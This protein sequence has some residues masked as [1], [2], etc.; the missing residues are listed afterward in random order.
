[1]IVEMLD[2][3]MNSTV[4]GGIKNTSLKIMSFE[5]SSVRV[6]LVEVFSI[7]GEGRPLLLL[8]FL[9]LPREHDDLT[10]WNLLS[11]YSP[12]KTGTISQKEHKGTTF[13]NLNPHFFL[14]ISVG[15]I[16]QSRGSNKF[17]CALV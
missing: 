2:N 3:A 9:P 17:R 5:F 13:L 16:L 14:T 8:C 6:E 10:F 11:L 7:S 4:N 1:M 12:I 15:T